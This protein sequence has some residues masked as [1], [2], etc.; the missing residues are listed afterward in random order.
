VIDWLHRPANGIELRRLLPQ[1]QRW[2]NHALL[3]LWLLGALF[4]GAGCNRAEPPPVAPLTSAG[5]S[6]TAQPKLQTLKLWIG[7]AELT[8]ELCLTD[9]QRMMGMMHRKSL[10][11]N[12]GMIF[13]FP[14]PHRAAFWMRNTLVPLSAAYIDS[15]GVIL[16]I[17]DLEPLN[18]TSVVAK[19]DQVQYVLEVNRGWFARN[20]L[21][22]GSVV[23]TER[24]S[25]R[26]TFFA[27]PPARGSN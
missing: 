7:A 2:M 15:E 5:D 19:S 6:Q 4:L 27:R 22:A 24:G 13:I 3:S 14:Y 1:A 10:E 25:L 9:Q 26:D 21:V 17:R 16:E 18:E 8:A 12:A 20:N 11:E 23:R